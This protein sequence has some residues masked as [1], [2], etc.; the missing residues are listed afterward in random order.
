[1]KVKNKEMYHIHR[2]GVYDDIW[3]IGNKLT[4]DDSFEALFNSNR[5]VPSGVRCKDGSIS[6]LDGFIEKV[7][8]VI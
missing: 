6:S 5:D 1:M 2:N 3:K 4:V 8:L 7:I